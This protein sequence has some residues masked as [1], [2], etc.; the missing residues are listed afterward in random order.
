MQLLYKE[1]VL[2]AHPTHLVFA[3]MGALVLVPAYPFS[4]IFMFGCL[5][6]YITLQYGRE[7]GDARFTALLPVARRDV[8]RGKFLLI[9]CLQFFQL[10]LSVPFACL[11]GALGMGG[12]PVGLDATVAWYG[13]GLMQYAVFDGIFLPVYYHTARRAGYAFLVAALPMALMM[14]GIESVAHIPALAWMDGTEPGELRRQ[15]PILLL[16]VLAYGGALSLAYRRSV[17]NFSRVDL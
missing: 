12:N 14:A 7:T 1:L 15:I 13:M 4:V 5:G 9:A 8:V 11:R 2:A 16:G 10:T 3:C 6:P 17:Q